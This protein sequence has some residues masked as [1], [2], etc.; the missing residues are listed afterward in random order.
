[1]IGYLH[2]SSVAYVTVC[3]SRCLPT[4][5]TVSDESGEFK[6]IS[7]LSRCSLSWAIEEISFDNF[8][9]FDLRFKQSNGDYDCQ[10]SRATPTR[11]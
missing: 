10:N 2:Q 11:G 1:M 5:R 9:A 3:L 6:K 7:R 4:K 8:R